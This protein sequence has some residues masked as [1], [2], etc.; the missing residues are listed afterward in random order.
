VLEFRHRY[1]FNQT[2]PTAVLSLTIKI[3]GY[4][5]LFIMFFSTWQESIKVCR[6]I[7][8]SLDPSATPHANH[9]VYLQYENVTLPTPALSRTAQTLD[10]TC[11]SFSFD[12]VPLSLTFC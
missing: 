11:H 12:E 1:M 10:P 7:I 9:P 5:P 2:K 6:L 4:F 8:I 3:L